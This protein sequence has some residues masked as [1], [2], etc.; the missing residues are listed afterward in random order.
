MKS[1]GKWIKLETVNL[2]GNP[3]PEKQMSYLLAQLWM[4]V[5]F[6]IPTGVRKLIRRLRRNGFQRRED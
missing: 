6:R 2:N 5:S 1:G 3:D 4:L